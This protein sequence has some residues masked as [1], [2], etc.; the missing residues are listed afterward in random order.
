M[1]A[2]L[3]KVIANLAAIFVAFAVFCFFGLLILAGFMG[4]ASQSSAPP[5]PE[6]A[7]LVLPLDLIIVDSPRE[8]GLAE[9]VVEA[10]NPASG[11]IVP[12][13]HLIDALDRAA[14][15][16]R[17][18]SLLLYGRDPGQLGTSMANVLEIRRAIE[19]FKASGKQVDAYLQDSGQREYL[20]ASTADHI[21]I[22]P[23]GGVSMTGF[24]FERVYFGAA[25]ERYGVG[26][27][28]SAAGAYKSAIDAFTRSGMSDND[29]EQLGALL[30][31]MSTVFQAEVSASRNLPD[32]K[33]VEMQGTL[34]LISADEM[35]QL[36]LVD[37]VEPRDMIVERLKDRVG[38]N[39]DETTF[40]QVTVSDYISARPMAEARDDVIA[41]VYIEGELVDGEGES[42]Q[43]GGD[44]IARQIRKLRADDDVKALVLRVNS[45]GGS[46][47][48][49]EIIR[50]EVE[51][52]AADRPVVVSM[53]SLAASGGYWVAVPANYSF[54]EPITITGSIGVF[55]LMVN[56]DD[57]AGNWGVT[58]ESVQTSEFADIYSIYEPRSPTEMARV[59]FLIQDIYHKFIALVAE[60]RHLATE[61]V[62]AI[63][64]GRVWSGLDAVD[65]KLVDSLGGIND[66]I[67]KAAALADL[68]Q[69]DYSLR[70]VPAEKT[71]EEALAE[72]LG[73]AK[74]GIMG[75]ETLA[76]RE[77]RELLEMLDSLKDSNNLFA[78][79]PFNLDLVW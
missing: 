57:L 74:A 33:V 71:F 8:V 28:A 6:S 53:G 36:G 17:I 1:K 15:D 37:S 16:E 61:D 66:A 46:A 73:S 7:V 47:S 54:A 34:G 41:V 42:D 43:A 38:E 3:V 59:D 10:L 35:L 14:E 77:Q 78:R 64:Q 45:P 18:K 62:E 39:D 40:S 63:A 76:Q 22:H 65:L 48:A 19:R 31:D 51:L 72:M 29:R 32:G 5:V 60:G 24:A 58:S 50:R 70:E 23:L 26:V 79:A 49:S 21:T 67:T 20:L 69:G 27:Q 55:S 75:P 9:A 30:D 13:K 11:E 68:E 25:F 2:F 44:R 12:L 52:F 4:A 56:I